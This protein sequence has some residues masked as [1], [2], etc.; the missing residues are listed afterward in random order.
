MVGECL[1]T[2]RAKGLLDVGC[3]CSGIVLGGLFPEPVQRW[4]LGKILGHIHFSGVDGRGARGEGHCM[5]STPPSTTA[6]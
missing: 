3:Y 5:E 6:T 1:G 2:V 4:V